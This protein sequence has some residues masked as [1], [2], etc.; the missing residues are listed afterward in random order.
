M[1]G[2]GS[3]TSPWDLT[4]AITSVDV[5]NNGN[6]T[7]TLW[8][9]GGTYSGDFNNLLDGVSDRRIIIRPYQNETVIID[10][11]LVVDGSYIT[12]MNLIIRNSSWTGRES[13]EEETPS[14]LPTAECN[15]RAVGVKFI[16][17]IIHD[18]LSLYIGQEAETAEFYGCLS[19]HHGWLA[20]IR[21]HGHA[22]YVQNSAV[23]QMLV[24]DCIFHDCFGWG[25][26]AYAGLG[27]LLKNIV[28]EGNASFK[29]GSLSG[30]ARPDILLGADSG[31]STGCSIK[32][33]MT[34]GGSVGVYFYEAG[35]ALED[36]TDNY[37]PNNKGQAWG[38]YTAVTESGNYW[39]PAVGNQVFLRPNDY[40]PNRAN[41][42]VYNQAE[43]NAINKDVSSIFGASGTVK[44]YNAQ[45]PFTDIQTLD[46]SSGV[47]TVN[48]QAANRTVATPHS[49]VAPAKS[50]PQF[51]AFILV[52]Q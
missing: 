26:H 24:K 49:W 42:I 32:S 6:I 19:Y 17:C 33:N 13:L 45:D 39:G 22:V 7:R 31:Q 23:T 2:N 40:D 3:I 46:I 29:S 38:G 35:A 43:A 8:L 14:D 34:Y 18:M 5:E 4:T 52:K 50:F 16:N 37:C 51:G 11:D 28:I 41:L 36:F 9:R 47:I 1:S 44:A 25:P 15:I 27:T 30:T 21:G 10:G 48:M 20:P 12:F